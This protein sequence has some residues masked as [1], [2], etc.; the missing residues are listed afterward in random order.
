M[1]HQQIQYQD[2]NLIVF[3]N[4]PTT[5]YDPQNGLF[6]RVGAD[7]QIIRQLL[8][9]EDGFV[10]VYLKN[11]TKTKRRPLKLAWEI[12]NLKLLPND[13]LVYPKNMDDTDYSAFNLCA[14]SKTEHKKLKD[15]I[16]NLEGALKLKPDPNKPHG[17][18]LMYF[19]NGRRVKQYFD[20]IV[21]AK[22]AKQKIAVECTKFV[23]KYSIT[24]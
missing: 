21:T 3:E 1:T 9:D 20:D 12:V 10:L 7:N 16:Q 14:I 13:F 24:L 11:N 5:A 4:Y 8:T 2:K 6:Y 18:I 23:S 19:N 22:Q 15:S 17:V